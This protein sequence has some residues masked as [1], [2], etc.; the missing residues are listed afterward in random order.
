MAEPVVGRRILWALPLGA[1]LALTL[2]LWSAGLG[3]ALRAQPVDTLLLTGPLTATA[4]TPVTFTAL[5]TATEPISY[6]WDFGA[7][8]PVTV[9]A[10]PTQSH[11]YPVPGVYTLA[12]TATAGLSEAVASRPI[13]ILPADAPISGV[14]AA[15]SGP[16]QVG[17]ATR[18]TATVSGGDNVA[19]TWSFGDGTTGTG[20][21]TTHV[22]TQAGVFTATVT[23]ANDAGSV[24][25]TTLVETAHLLVQVVDFEFRPRFVTVLPGQTVLWQRRQGIH[26]V[27]AD[28]Q[29]GGVPSFEQPLSEAWT[30]FRHTFPELGRYGYHCSLHGDPGGVAMAGTVL[31]AWPTAGYL[32]VI[33]LAPPTPEPDPEPEPTP[34]P[35]PEEP[36]A[37]D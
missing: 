32:P 31:V 7:G 11:I 36:T 14:S 6:A 22:Y 28:T 4:R 8:A 9:T 23:A 24:Q 25:A 1:L 27:T 29:V 3:P 20:L 2:L 37:H 18:F 12:V 5:F 10:L 16:S 30:T 15:N 35:T 34:E 26:S 13:H 19:V 33:T 21:T 17:L